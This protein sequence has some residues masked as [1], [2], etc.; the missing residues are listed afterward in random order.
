MLNKETDTSLSPEE[1]ERVQR[2]FSQY[3]QIAELLHTS[4]D[5]EQAEAALTVVNDLSK[6]A[7]I[8][9]VKS[10][11]KENET[12]A[13]D[14][15]ASINAISQVKEVRKEARRGLLRLESS[16]ILPQWKPPVTETPAAQVSI[17]KPPRFWKGFASQTREEGE[18]QILLCW[19]QGFEYNEILLFAFVLNYW[20]DG[21]KDFFT[22]TGSRR[23]I[24]GRINEL[25]ASLSH[26]TLVDCTLAEGK[27]LIEEAL[28]INE[29]R[30]VEPHKDYR[31]H[32]PTL[33]TLIFQATDLGMDR[34]DS[35][36]TPDLE[37]QEVLVN[38]LG[39]WTF[40]DFGLAYDL[41]TEDC[42]IRD[43]L[44]RDEWVKQHRQWHQEAEPAR[45]ELGFVHELPTRQSTLWVP[46][47][48]SKSLAPQKKEVEVGWSVELTETPLSGTLKEMPFATAINK[49]TGRSWFWT[50]YTLVRVNNAWRIQKG[51]DEGLALQGATPDD[52]QKRIA[53]YKEAID[54][55]I[56]QQRQN[57]NVETFLEE[58]SWRLSQLLHFYDTLIIQF[59]LD[60]EICRQAYE[61]AILTG[62]PERVIVYLERM[63]QRFSEDRGNNLRQLGSTL[64]E[65]ADQDAERD[66]I[67]RSK[68]LLKRAEETLRE[69]ISTDEEALSR[70][71][72]GELFISQDRFAEAE[73]ELLAAKVLPHTEKVEV[74][75]EAAL[76]HTMMMSERMAEAIT[77]Y[78]R[79]RELDPQYPDVWLNL[80][81]AHRQL[82]QM[83]EAEQ[84]Y[85]RAI[86][87]NPNDYRPY[88]EL[89]IVYAGREEL[90]KAVDLLK[91]GLQTMPDSAILH[92]LIAS[93]LHEQGH[94]LEA[95][96]HLA[97]A[98]SID[99][100]LRVVQLVKE[101]ING[102][103]Q[104]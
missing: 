92:A 64:A 95:Q 16:K 34:G 76:G 97:M 57:P 26:S 46:P 85:L 4:L 10:L 38:F 40:G 25:R 29:W 42:E 35:F 19:E 104:K 18:M 28:S 96:R 44:S 82:G 22:E 31:D 49:E 1:T 5:Q 77:H 99:P 79:V 78:Q 60:Y 69:A 30:N 67:V 50:S 74:A 45:M 7:Q 33:N 47:S 66:L 73:A 15:L 101:E 103:R 32:L 39:A 51:A 6:A 102:S 20:S 21:I 71:L 80:G 68:Q 87:V 72:L 36:I 37:T 65:L 100:E 88:S 56:Q 41:L 62:R 59:P 63:T 48:L 27:R 11:A 12:D 24:N 54:Q 53:E 93:A 70:T 23:T 14:I 84:N 9:F 91:R 83:D 13:A 55:L 81:F 75:T 52:L 86:E 61:S 8:A 2:L 3:H 89:T 58:A 98:E 43:N 17:S 90:G 94:Q